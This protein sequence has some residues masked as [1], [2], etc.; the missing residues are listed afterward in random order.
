MN[1]EQKK[2]LLEKSKKGYIKCIL[3]LVEIYTS[4]G[5]DSGELFDYL[6]IPTSTIEECTKILIDKTICSIAN[7][8]LSIKEL[9]STKEEYYKSLEKEDL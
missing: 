5:G 8:T 9:E 6:N 1:G 4:N 7:L 3:G 2:K